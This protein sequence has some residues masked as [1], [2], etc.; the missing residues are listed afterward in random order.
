MDKAGNAALSVLSTAKVILN[1]LAVIYI[2][3]IGI[4]M[5]I[6]YGDDGTLSK[7]KKQLMYALVAFLFVNIPG[8]LY[9]IITAGRTTGRDV[10]GTPT[11]GDFVISRTTGTNLFINFDLWNST[12]ENGVLAFIR[13]LVIG[14]AVF[15]FT[16]AGFKLLVSRGNE[17]SIKS[18]K[19]QAIYGVLSLVF[20]GVIQAWVSV[21]YSGDIPRG[22]SVFASLANLAI[23]FA[24]PVAIFFLTLGA[25]YYIT[26]AGEEE[27]AKK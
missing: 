15:Y 14:L 17:E 18:G 13:I 2:V 21:V 6:A 7:Q 23:F 19:S 16:L 12:I 11:G 24:G 26:S 10:T 25:Y 5:V 3:Y 9:N 8:Q 27:R 20:L 1:G 4:M 22:Q